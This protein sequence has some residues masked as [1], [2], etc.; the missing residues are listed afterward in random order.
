MLDNESLGGE[1][2]GVDLVFI[3]ETTKVM[4]R[5]PSHRTTLG[6]WAFWRVNKWTELF[7]CW[8]APGLIRCLFHLSTS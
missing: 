2:G 4:K 6:F 1:T 3:Q 7:V 5:P 8:R